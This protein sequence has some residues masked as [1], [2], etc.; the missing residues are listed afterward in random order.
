MNEVMIKQYEGSNIF[1]MEDGWF[2][3]TEVSVRYGQKP[4]D[5]LTLPKT[6]EL[7]LALLKRQSSHMAT[8][9]E[10]NGLWEE[11]K[12]SGINANLMQVKVLDL[13]KRTGCVRTKRGSPENGGGTWMHPKLAVHFGY[14][15][16]VNFAIW[17]GERIE[18]ILK[19][20][21][22]DSMRDPYPA[23]V[24]PVYGYPVVSMLEDVVHKTTRKS[25][26]DI[27]NALGFRAPIYKQTLTNNVSQILIGMPIKP[28]RRLLGIPAGSQ[29]RTRLRMDY[30]LRRATAKIE[31]TA[32][33]M[34][35]NDEDITTFD[36]IQSVVYQVAKIVYQQHL[37]KGLTL[38]ENVP[39]T[40]IM[41]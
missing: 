25:Y 22:N 19:S 1:F 15:L 24:H 16:D 37:V 29:A 32:C 40:S 23:I 30:N 11:L 4:K 14:W 38:Q 7:I 27:L 35:D 8:F 39:D 34:I 3:A 31:E 20:G 33:F 21:I 17:V 36:Q 18:E 28:Y 13:V 10:I 5:W 9:N 41:A 6:L 2:N 26:I 12:T